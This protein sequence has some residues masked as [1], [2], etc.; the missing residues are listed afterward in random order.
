MITTTISGQLKE[1]RAERVEPKVTLLEES[2]RKGAAADS[3]HSR[4]RG[5]EGSNLSGG[6]EQA[7]ADSMGGR[8]TT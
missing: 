6:N 4:R 2:I 1:E 7:G 3:I 5:T 8:R